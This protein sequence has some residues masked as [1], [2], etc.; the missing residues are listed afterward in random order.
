MDRIAGFRPRG[1]VFYCFVSLFLQGELVQFHVFISQKTTV[2][3]PWCINL[4]FNTSRML[5]LAE[6]REV[7]Q[8]AT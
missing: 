7:G 3:Q 2:I 1:C 6:R 8:D 4:L 5:L